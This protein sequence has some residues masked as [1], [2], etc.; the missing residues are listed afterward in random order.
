MPTDVSFSS[1]EGPGAGLQLDGFL[2]LYEEIYAEPPY[3]EGPRD[4][5]EF[6]ERFGRQSRRPGFRL[7]L[8]HK[9][10]GLVGFSFGYLLPADTRWWNGLLEP[11]PAAFTKETGE[12]TFA[13][14]E[15][16]VRAACRRRGIAAGLHAR[17]LDG[18]Q[19]ER[20]ALTVRPEPEA[21]PARCAYA[22]WGYRRIGRSRPWD[23]APLYDA[24]VLG[25]R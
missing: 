1:Y 13:V 21:A 15:L 23:G 19:A 18:L 25:L 2:A 9:G 8:A 5:A 12:R 7:V 16:A 4:V 24:M 20:V 3:C 6:I 10:D 17:L 14:I 11:G 22:A